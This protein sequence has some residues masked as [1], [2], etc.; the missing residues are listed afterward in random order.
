M[1]SIRSYKKKKNKYQTLKKHKYS[2]RRIYGCVKTNKRSRMGASVI[3][4]MRGGDNKAIT[5]NF[6]TITRYYDD[7]SQGYFSENPENK[8]MDVAVNEKIKNILT[9]TLKSALTPDD[10]NGIK[11]S[12]SNNYSFTVSFP[13]DYIIDNNIIEIRKT[14]ENIKLTGTFEYEYLIDNN[15]NKKEHLKGTIE[16]RF[17]INN[18]VPLTPRKQLTEKPPNIT[19]GHN[20]PRENTPN[21][22][23]LPSIQEEEYNTT[24]TNTKTSS[25]P[26][27]LLPDE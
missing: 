6:F 25:S 15:H 16:Y 27:N 23:R 13:D 20:K 11:V 10:D 18:S 22:R 1:I 5:L 12:S 2:K 4:K 9:K 21:R 17:Y 26:R 8:T 24:P 7:D 14:I 3:K 19:F